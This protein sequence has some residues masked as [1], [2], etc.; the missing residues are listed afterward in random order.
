MTDSNSTLALCAKDKPASHGR[1][2]C[3]GRTTRRITTP[4]DLSHTMETT[5]T[6]NNFISR[7][8]S[9]ARTGR[10]SPSTCL[11][12]SVANLC[13]LYSRVACYSPDRQSPCKIDCPDRSR[14]RG[15]LGVISTDSNTVTH[16]QTD[17]DGS[18]SKAMT[19]DRKT[20]RSRKVGRR[21]MSTVTSNLFRRQTRTAENLSRAT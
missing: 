19:K 21:R 8:R 17:G 7:L 3:N 16:V 2:R 12:C 11:T 4:T 15:S 10:N 20:G 6:S 13:H 9:E 18:N 14:S 1:V 5:E